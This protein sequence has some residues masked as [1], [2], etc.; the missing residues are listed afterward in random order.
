[1]KVHIL[2]R[3]KAP[4]GGRRNTQQAGSRANCPV[5]KGWIVFRLSEAEPRSDWVL[6]QSSWEEL[7]SFH[8]QLHSQ[9]KQQVLFAFSNDSLEVKIDHCRRSSQGALTH[10]DFFFFVGFRFFFFTC[11]ERK[12]NAKCTQTKEIQSA[13]IK[14]REKIREVNQNKT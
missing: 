5:E 12:K 4:P 6:I 7:S 3:P 1:M 11:T 9:L 8:P 14:K 10:V 2:W 13:V